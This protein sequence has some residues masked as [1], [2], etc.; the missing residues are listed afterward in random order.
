MCCCDFWR[1]TPSQ[2]HTV[3]AGFVSALRLSLVALAV[4][5]ALQRLLRVKALA[6]LLS[7]SVVLLHAGAL[8]AF[9]FHTGALALPFR[10][11]DCCVADTP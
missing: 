10:H 3:D 7:G 2:I 9:L 11:D 4:T 1:V 6:G 5:V 8:V